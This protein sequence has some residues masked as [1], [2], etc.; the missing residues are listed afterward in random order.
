MRFSVFK[1]AKGVKEPPTSASFKIER[2]IYYLLTW[3]S[4]STERVSRK[5]SLFLGDD[6]TG[7]NNM[8]GMKM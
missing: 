5:S 2:I 6:F 4:I 3:I 8:T 7:R 1:K